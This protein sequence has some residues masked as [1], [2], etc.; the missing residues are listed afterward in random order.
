MSLSFGLTKN[1]D[2]ANG[3]DLAEILARS[4][5]SVQQYE[6][7]KCGGLKQKLRELQSRMHQVRNTELLHIKKVSSFNVP[8]LF[9]NVQ[10]RPL[11]ISP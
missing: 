2:L 3:F 9:Q 6:R 10:H 4:S 11:L 8:S 5:S 7:N 1:L